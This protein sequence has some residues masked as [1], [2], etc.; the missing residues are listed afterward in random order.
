MGQVTA[1]AAAFAIRDSG[2]RSLTQ[3]AALKELA[4]VAGTALAALDPLRSPAVPPERQKT[5]E[6]TQRLNQK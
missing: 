4:R 2:I 1:H 3:A 5:P 6:K